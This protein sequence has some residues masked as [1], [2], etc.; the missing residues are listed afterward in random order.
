MKKIKIILII[1][2]ACIGAILI[3]EKFEVDKPSEITIDKHLSEYSLLTEDNV[4]KFKNI[5][6]IIN[7]LTH[8][9]GII[10]FCS[11]SSNW[12]QYYLKALNDIAKE[13]NIK[14]IYYNDIKEDRNNNSL[15]YQKIVNILYD[16]LDMD[17][18]NNKR[19]NMPCLVFIKDGNLLAVDTK[20]SIVSSEIIPEDYWS[21]KDNINAFNNQINE[22]I[23]LLNKENVEEVIK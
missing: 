3:Y 12:C 5:D 17:D 4:F 13:N 8:N 14:E 23:Y 9:T 2:I 11:P 1:I 21:D 6:S 7:I 18:T 20:Y 15:K 22:Y 10:L 19:L 16:Y